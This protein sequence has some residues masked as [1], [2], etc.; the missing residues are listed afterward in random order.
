MAAFLWQ[1]EP[2]PNQN[3]HTIVAGIRKAL[4]EAEKEHKRVYGVDVYAVAHFDAWCIAHFRVMTVRVKA[5]IT[6]WLENLDQSLPS[7]SALR[8]RINNV[9]QAASNLN[10]DITTLFPHLP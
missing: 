5:W 4:R 10:F 9:R 7:N 3:L 1:S 8:N 6:V 2:T